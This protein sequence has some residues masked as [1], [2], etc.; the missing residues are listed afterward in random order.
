[1]E[2]DK[3]TEV[4]CGG[5]FVVRKEQGIGECKGRVTKLFMY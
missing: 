3:E 1:M 2:G 4:K 5:G